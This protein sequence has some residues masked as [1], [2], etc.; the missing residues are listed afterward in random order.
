MRPGKLQWAPVSELG[1][2]QARLERLNELGFD[3]EEYELREES[4]FASVDN[5]LEAHEDE[6]HVLP[7]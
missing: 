1:R 2:I 5:V 4:G 6:R 3:T 7:E